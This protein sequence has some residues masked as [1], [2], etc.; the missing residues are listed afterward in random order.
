LAIVGPAQS[1]LLR[2]FWSG[3]YLSR[4]PT[5]P[6]WWHGVTAR[7]GLL[8]HDWML[9][10]SLFGEAFTGPVIAL[11]VAFVVASALVAVRRPLHGLLFGIPVVIAVLASLAQ[12]APLGT[13][14]VDVWLYAPMA[15]MIATGV[16]ILLELGGN[17][18]RPVTRIGSMRSRRWDLALGGGV[19]VLALLWMFNIPSPAAFHYEKYD[20]VPLVREMEASRSPRDLVVVSLPLTFNYALSAP[21]PFTTKVS[22][23]YST[24]FT[25]VV[26]GVNAMNWVDYPAP[27]AEFRAR[28]RG[29]RDVWLLDT[30]KIFNA[31]GAAPRNE[32]AAQGF[33]RLTSFRNRL[34]VLEHW[35]RV[36]SFAV[37]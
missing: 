3:F 36:S 13:G 33:A 2:E 24:H 31:L 23:R 27:M 30:P 4:T 9:V 35:S 18:Y 6:T 12:V 21:Q 20:V 25:P 15:F 22:D 29:T 16:D 8:A 14:R 1:P 10:K 32:L 5:P 37:P 7:P 34:T 26:H 11:V 28:L 17:A 19:A